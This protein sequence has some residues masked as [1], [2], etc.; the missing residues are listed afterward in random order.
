MAQEDDEDME[1]NLGNF[2]S[3]FVDVLTIEIPQ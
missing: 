3:W 2:M 1:Q